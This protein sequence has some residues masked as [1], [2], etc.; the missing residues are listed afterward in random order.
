MGAGDRADAGHRQVDL[1]VR[2]RAKIRAHLF[3]HHG[4]LF[5][6][7]D[8]DPGVR[9]R[10]GAVAAATGVATPSWGSRSA[11]WIAPA[12]WSRWWRR[13]RARTAVICGFVSFAAC[14]GVGALISSSRA[15]VL[16]SSRDA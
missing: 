2:V 6:Q 8:Q 13:C 10:S 12:F 4:Y 9:G 3:F 7:G 16:V 15:S 1:S 11:S 14:S 5:V